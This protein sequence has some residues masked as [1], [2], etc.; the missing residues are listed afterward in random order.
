MYYMSLILLIDDIEAK[1]NI[2]MQ[3]FPVYLI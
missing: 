2:D 3:Y 1:F